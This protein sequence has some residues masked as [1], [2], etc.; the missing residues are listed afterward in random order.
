MELAY[1]V[2]DQDAYVDAA[3]RPM[4]SIRRRRERSPPSIE[5]EGR[6]VAAIVHDADLADER[7]LVQAV[8]RRGGAHARE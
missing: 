3:G 6:R 5:H 1:W 2:P 8:G 7:E 4:R